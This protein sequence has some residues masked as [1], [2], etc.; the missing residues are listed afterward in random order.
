MKKLILLTI[1]TFLLV[2]PFIYAGT[3]QDLFDVALIIIQP[4]INVSNNEVE[5]NRQGEVTSTITYDETTK[6]FGEEDLDTSDGFVDGHIKFNNDDGWWT[7]CRNQTVFFLTNIDST[8]NRAHNQIAGYRDDDDAGWF[9]VDVDS[10]GTDIEAYAEDGD[11]NLAYSMVDNEKFFA[12]KHFKSVAVT[13]NTTASKTEVG[14]YINGTFRSYYDGATTNGEYT[15]K[16]DDRYVGWAQ[17]SQSARKTVGNI[18][19]LYWF[20]KSLTPT[21]V[22]WLHNFVLAGN[23]LEEEPPAIVINNTK[24][25]ISI[26][27]PTNAST[28][29]NTSEYPLR[30]YGNATVQNGSINFT[31]INSTDWKNIGNNTH[32]NFTFNGS[33]REGLWILNISTNSS[34]GNRTD[35]VLTITV[36]LTSPVLV[37]ALSTNATLIYA[38]KNLTFNI[39]S[40]D[41]EKVYYFNISTPEGYFLEFNDTNT[42]K[43]IF[44]GSINVSDYGVGRHNIT[45]ETCDAHTSKLI[46]EFDNT[47]GKDNDI[48]FYFGSRYIAIEPL[49]KTTISG[50]TTKKELDRYTFTYTKNALNL[51]EDIGF[52]ITSTDYI[53]IIGNEGKYRGWLV[54][55]KLQKWIDFN[56]AEMSRLNYKI[57]RIS[58]TSVKVEI[59]G[60]KG[61]T[62]T[63]NSIG[64]VNCRKEEYVYYIYNFTVDYE[65]RATSST[66][67]EINF[68]IDYKD[69]PLNSTAVMEYN[70]TGYALT[71]TSSENQFNYTI[72]I[73]PQQYTTI[74]K[75]VNISFNYTLNNTQYFTLN[76]TQI[77]DSVFLTLFGNLTNTSAINFTFYDEMNN[78]QIENA[79]AEGTFNYLTSSVFS[80]SLTATNN[81]S[82]AIYPTGA[83]TSGDYVVYYSGVGYTERRY[84]DNNAIY[85]NNTQLIKL[86]MLET[87]SGGYATFRVEDTYSNPL[88]D[89]LCVMEKVIEGSTVTVEQQLTDASGL[90]TFFV[91]PD[92]DYIFTF[93]KTGYETYSA[94]IRPITTEIYTVTLEAEEEETTP[95]FAT[96][97]RYTFTPINTILNNHTNYNFTFNL[98]SDYWEITDCNLTIKNYTNNLIS[99]DSSY[100]TSKCSIRIEFNTANYSK[101]ISEAVYRL[102]DTVEERVAMQYTVRYTY[103]GEFSLWNFIQDLKSFA[104]AGFNDFTRM[105]LAFIVI[106]SIVAFLSTN[107]YSLRD[108]EVLIILAWALVL[109]FS[110]TGFLTL[111]LESIPDIVGLKQYIIFYLFTL[112]A[113]SYIIRRHL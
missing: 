6:Y 82:V 107:Y 37:S 104:E 92:D 28:I 9:M 63:F 70:K 69:I 45:A 27:Y 108:P 48:T 68:I 18:S 29:G 74:T 51:Q 38:Y 112:G 80:P 73:T 8:N 35:Y 30:I 22:L 89:V 84:S 40:T 4:A 101:L 103:A 76:Y 109:F 49:D 19:R 32:Y 16:T 11:S 94:T 42:T 61:N 59:E 24:P 105:I 7:P 60:I 99:S 55:P 3:Q 47:I 25:N 110:Y 44:N 13:L 91:N 23:I 12:G 53:D 102:N 90:A 83:S 50:L 81:L 39:N 98:T 26:H 20:N 97:T 106:F 62:F 58:D 14:I 33:M 85:N 71:N 86:Y 67:T 34:H 65:T 100:T 10:A 5:N 15:G 2:L 57:T 21:E 56:T 77:I 41:S 96:G 66:P 54:I 1:V 78:S 46:P 43:Y 75:N 64:T 52:L 36:D 113:G 72:N 88:S 17:T 93:S 111:N 31:V 95:S 79:N 87:A